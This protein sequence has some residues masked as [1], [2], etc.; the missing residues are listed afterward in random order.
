VTRVVRTST[1]SVAPSYA[2]E[3]EPAGL[4]SD[5]TISVAPKARAT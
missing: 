1:T 4:T 3:G 2:G 5:T